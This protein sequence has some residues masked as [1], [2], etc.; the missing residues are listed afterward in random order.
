MFIALQHLLHHQLDQDHEPD[1]EPQNPTIGRS[2]DSASTTEQQQHG[3]STQRSGLIAS[4]S[5]EERAL[6]P[7]TPPCVSSPNLPPLSPR[8]L[9]SSP[10]R[11]EPPRGSPSP[12]RHPFSAP[13][14][15]SPKP[16]AH[17][18]PRREAVDHRDNSRADKIAAMKKVRAKVQPPA[19]SLA[20]STSTTM[21]NPKGRVITR[22]RGPRRVMK[23][24]T[25]TAVPLQAS[26]AP[27]NQAKHSTTTVP[28]KRMAADMVVEDVE[29]EPTKEEQLAKKQKGKPKIVIPE[30]DLA[31][32]APLPPSGST[33]DISSRDP[34]VASSS[35]H[36]NAIS[37]S[38]TIGA[39]DINS[40]SRLKNPLTS[41]AAVIGR[42][43]A[44]DTP[45]LNFVFCLF[46]LSL[47]V[48]TLQTR[49]ILFQ[50][51]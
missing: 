33:I 3:R 4:R 24:V 30:P 15:P 49:L 10:H 47:P 38:D 25:W 44:L 50:R 11:P 35:K 13:R 17:K 6:L 2:S 29:G 36:P 45:P 9:S 27:K 12:S 42:L 23:V 37:S 8:H 5:A 7:P 41:Q 28:K 51:L 20:A 26:K 16:R 31:T 40:D 14:A 43:V 22:R 48:S 19:K 46:E 39:E 34:P 1:N 21:S 32:P 18:R